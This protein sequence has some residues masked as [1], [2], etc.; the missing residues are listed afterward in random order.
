MDQREFEIV[1]FRTMRDGA[2]EEE[3]SRWSKRGD[4]RCTKIGSFLRRLSIDELPQ[5]L[6][7]IKGEMSLIGPR[8]ERPC[9]VRQFSEEYR[10]YMLRHKVKAGMTGW[11]QINGLRGDTSLR[12]RLVYDLYYVRNWS[13][14]FDLWILLLTPRHVLKGENAY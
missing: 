4:Q 7:V 13:F 1:K 14:G 6:N 10:R 8:P 3:G 9:F 12:K 11:A 2:E 5:L